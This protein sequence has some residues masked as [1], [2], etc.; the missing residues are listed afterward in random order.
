MHLVDTT[1]IA[2]LA[3]SAEI[4]RLFSS[5]GSASSALIVV[6]NLQGAAFIRGW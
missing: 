4:R 1:I 3:E 2:E 5:A 6:A